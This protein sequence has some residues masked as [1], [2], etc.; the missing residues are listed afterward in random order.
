MRQNLLQ[1]L[2][3]TVNRVLAS[4]ALLHQRYERETAFRAW[5]E[6]RWATIRAQRLLAALELQLVSRTENIT[7]NLPSL[8]VM[9]Q[10]FLLSHLAL[11]HALCTDLPQWVVLPHLI[12]CFL[13]RGK[14][15]LYWFA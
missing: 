9:L 10:S 13:H 3:L 6:S 7:V 8:L 4:Q 11:V 5:Q 15:T 12:T 2:V 14:H 1:V